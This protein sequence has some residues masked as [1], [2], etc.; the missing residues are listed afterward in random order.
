MFPVESKELQQKVM[1]ALDSMFLDN[2]KSRW[3]QPDGSYRRRKPAKGEEPFRVQL[4]LYR[5]AQRAL[6]RARAGAGVTFE[7]LDGRG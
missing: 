5:E 4:H 1:N 6:E 3:L 7:P 2:V